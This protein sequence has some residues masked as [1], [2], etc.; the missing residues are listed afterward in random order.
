MGLRT[1]KVVTRVD[2]SRVFVE[3]R[4]HGDKTIQV[5]I[6]VEDVEVVMDRWSAQSKRDNTVKVYA[7][8]DG[9]IPH[10][11]QATLVLHDNPVY[12][13]RYTI[14]RTRVCQWLPLAQLQC[15]KSNTHEFM[16]AGSAYKPARLNMCELL[17][18]DYNLRLHF[19]SA[20]K[21]SVWIDAVSASTIQLLKNQARDTETVSL[22]DNHFISELTIKRSANHTNAAM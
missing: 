11:R 20:S 19:A 21:M 14:G 17:F 13:I 3:T 7:L 10:W 1:S 18:E 12:A 4:D 16:I 22:R 6:S 9:W 2:G 8:S 5:Q 15:I